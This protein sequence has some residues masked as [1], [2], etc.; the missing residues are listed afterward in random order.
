[1]E[2]EGNNANGEGGISMGMSIFSL[3]SSHSSALVSLII[4]GGIEI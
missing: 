1:M 3:F 4:G 2:E